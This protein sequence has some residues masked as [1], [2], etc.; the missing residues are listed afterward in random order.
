LLEDII[1]EK[2][3]VASLQMDL[4]AMNLARIPVHESLDNIALMIKQILHCTAE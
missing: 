2:A 4:Q 3:Q 1:A